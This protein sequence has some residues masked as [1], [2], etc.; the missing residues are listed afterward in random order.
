[1]RLIQ[2]A[3]QVAGGDGH[4]V[5]LAVR[6]LADGRTVVEAGAG[7]RYEIKGFGGFSPDSAL[8][9][10]I[11][12][13]GATGLYRSETGEPVARWQPLG[14]RPVDHLGFTPDGWLAA[15][16]QGDELVLVDLPGVRR[17]LAEMGLDW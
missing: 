10:L 8:V 3:G 11:G 1:M 15:G 12:D 2:P 17:R 7:K 5:T 4:T 9:A 6:D 14:G 13:D 16:T